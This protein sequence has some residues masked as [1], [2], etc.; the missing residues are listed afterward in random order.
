MNIAHLL[1]NQYLPHSPDE[2]G[3]GGVTRVALELARAQV[4]MGHQVS[5]VVVDREKWSTAWRGVRLRGVPIHHRARVRVGSCRF[6]FRR[7]LPYLLFTLRQPVDV[8]QG[9]AYSYMRFLRAPARLVH[10]HGDPFY[11]GRKN[12]GLDLKQADFQNIARF[13]HAQIAV[14]QF[15]ADELQRGFGAA[16]SVHVVHNGVNTEHF[17]P[18][19]WPEAGAHLRRTHGIPAHAVVF[20]F[21]GAMVPEKGVLHLARAFVQLA[22][23]TSDTHLMLAGGSR[24]WGSAFANKNDH[25]HYEHQVAQELQPLQAA[26]RAHLLGKVSNAQMPTLYAACDMLILPSTCREAFPLVVLEALAC[27]RPVIGSQTGGIV[28]L[29]NDQTGMLVEPGN[30]HSLETAMR[31][32][33]DAPA[34]RAQ[35][36]TAARQQALRFSWKTA[37]R[38]LDTIYQQILQQKRR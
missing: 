35:L 29:I 38:T 23:E 21:A 31:T 28:E 10:Y 24:L 18:H 1:G 37:A 4:A 25:D 34:L 26:G 11:R 2:E 17:S 3:A 16:G 15:V 13:S 33:R 20:L 5:V 27:G 9:H 22:A 14:S 32:L 36:G 6:D 30:Q 7:H 19:L 12:E 8:V